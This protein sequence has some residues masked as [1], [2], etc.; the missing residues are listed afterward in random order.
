[1]KIDSK[2][3]QTLK[4]LQCNVTEEFKGEKKNSVSTS[5]FKMIKIESD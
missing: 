2:E 4:S 1:M 3:F 5:L